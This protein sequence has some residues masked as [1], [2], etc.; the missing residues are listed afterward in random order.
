MK[1]ARL[2]YARLKSEA[3][4]ASQKRL[5]ELRTEIELARLD[6]KFALKQ[7]KTFVSAPVPI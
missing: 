1:L 7:W 5:A 2:E 6:F 3:S 4:V